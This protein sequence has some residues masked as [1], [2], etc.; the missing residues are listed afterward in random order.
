MQQPGYPTFESTFSGEMYSG[1]DRKGSELVSED[2][3]YGVGDGSG[4][5][6]PS[7]IRD[8]SP[9]SRSFSD[10]PLPPVP[11]SLRFPEPQINIAT[12]PIERS[13]S[14]RSGA[15]DPLELLKRYDTIF[16]IDDSSSMQGDKWVEVSR[17]KVYLHQR[18]EIMHRQEKL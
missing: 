4:P 1:Y 2:H 8:H 5:S 17:S 14:T 7:A 18:T 6:G 9:S 3:G 10:R 12:S 11:G 16:L 15:G 13:L